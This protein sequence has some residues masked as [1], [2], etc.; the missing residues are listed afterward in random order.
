L[1]KKYG[2]SFYILDEQKV[3]DN[4]LELKKAFTSIY[5][6]MNIAY[7]YKTNYTPR[8]CR[9]IND[10]GG[11][12]EVVS[13]MEYEITKKIGVSTNA[14]IFNG[15]YKVAAAVEEILLNNG[16]I[17]VDS[18]TDF[19]IVKQIAQEY[20]ARKIGIGLRCNFDVQDGVISRFGI[21]VETKNF[22]S[23]VE[24]IKRRPNL[25]LKNLHCHFANRSLK[26]WKN[27]A[28]YVFKIIDK[29]KFYDLQQIDLGGGI[30]GRMPEDLQKQFGGK[31]PTY[32][33]YAKVV[34]TQF[35]VRFKDTEPEKRPLLVIEP[36]TAIVGDVMKFATKVVSI[37][38]V[39]G[40][41]IATLLGSI[42]NINPTLNTKNPPLEIYTDAPEEQKEFKDLDFGGYTCIESDYLYKHFHG[43]LG[44]TD[45]VVFGNAGSYSVVLKP[46]FILP[47]FAVLSVTQ[48]GKIDLIKDRETFNNIFQTY[49]F[50]E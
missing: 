4:F 1:A 6:Q 36:G 9:I 20:P 30:Y 50:G 13:D 16:I 8:I 32:N 40:K 23:I 22:E 25:Y 3:K 42:Y 43:K 35:A 7:S 26:Y 37:K 17:N 18:Q 34:A 10:L 44:L 28:P 33:D 27:R 31:I 49:Q 21:D 14:V 41:D 19:A 46:P 24:E 48:T 39:R 5:P 2:E 45:Y 38:N 11:F 12:A 47:N 15:P 29:Y